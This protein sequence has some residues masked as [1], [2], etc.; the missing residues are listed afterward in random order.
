MTKKAYRY[1]SMFQINLRR[2][3]IKRNRLRVQFNRLRKDYKEM[4]NVYT[5]LT[6]GRVV[7]LRDRISFWAKYADEHG[8]FI[9][10]SAARWKPFHNANTPMKERG[11]AQLLIPPRRRKI[12]GFNLQR[13]LMCSYFKDYRFVTI[14]CLIL[15]ISLWWME[16]H[17]LLFQKTKE[18]QLG[19]P[20]T[21]IQDC[22][23]TFVN[24]ICH[25]HGNPIPC[26]CGQDELTI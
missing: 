25:K 16:V 24:H 22:H 9:W 20:L 1:S 11:L 8:Y 17:P 21:A 3:R 4:L 2:M 15:G 5:L 7:L 19:S 23:D 6:S 26:G 14:T 12:I 13:A 10:L 18:L